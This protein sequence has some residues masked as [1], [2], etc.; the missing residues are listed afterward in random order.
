M[1]GST[2]PPTVSWP[3]EHATAQLETDG[4]DYA[5]AIPAACAGLALLLVISVLFYNYAK[6][7]VRVVLCTKRKTTVTPAMRT[8]SYRERA[9]RRHLTD[10]ILT[11]SEEGLDFTDNGPLCSDRDSFFEVRTY[12]VEAE[13][14][15]E[16]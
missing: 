8:T 15:E 12:E 13:T 10:A 6:T 7:R 5:A 3:S 2:A 11:G 14:H 9:T 4:V 16:C 1:S